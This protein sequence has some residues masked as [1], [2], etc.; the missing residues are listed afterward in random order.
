MLS[1][2]Q[3]QSWSYYLEFDLKSSALDTDGRYILIIATVQGSDYLLANIY[4][5]NKVQEQCEF[6]SCLDKLVEK[7]H[8]SAEQKIVLGGDNNLL[9][10]S[11]RSGMGWIR[12]Q[13]YRERFCKV[14]SRYM[15]KL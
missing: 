4:A 3:S 5:P 9:Q 11:S 2:H 15:F 14:H 7:C 12:W 6:F 10:C 13:P 1:R 8:V